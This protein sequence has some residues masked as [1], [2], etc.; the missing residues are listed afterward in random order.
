MNFASKV[1]PVRRRIHGATRSR[2]D[3]HQTENSPRHFVLIVTAS[4]MVTAR[5][6]ERCL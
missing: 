6:L 1:D 3:F 2:A 5:P 4:D